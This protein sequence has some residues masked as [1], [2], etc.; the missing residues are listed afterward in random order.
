MGTLHTTNVVRRARVPTRGTLH[1]TNV[2][3]RVPHTRHRAHMCQPE[4]RAD[5]V[6]PGVP[7][8]APAGHASHDRCRV[9]R[10]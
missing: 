2:V 3:R 9:S 1:T 7:T 8:G 4:S 6:S 5:G 10:T